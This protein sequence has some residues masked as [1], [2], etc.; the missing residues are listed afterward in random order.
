MNKITVS[1][2]AKLNFNLH[3]LPQKLADG[4]YEVRFLNHQ[5]GLADEIIL[6]ESANGTSLICDIKQTP[7]GEKNLA[8][9]AAQI[10]MSQFPDRGGIKI[11]LKK[12]IPVAGGLGGGSADAA[13]VI[14]GLDK[15]WKLNLKKEE[16]LKIAQ[17]LGMDV[18]Y[19]V[20]GGTCLVTGAG[21][22]IEKLPFSI[23][24]IP[25]L[26]VS[27]TLQKP[28][29]SWAYGQ[30]NSGKIGRN[31]HKLE[32]LTAAIKEKNIVAIAKNLYN[33]FE[34]PIFAVY[35]E[36][37]EIK[38][39]MIESGALGSLLAGSGLSVFGLYRD[40]K[41]A[42]KAYHFLQKQYHQVF[43]TRVL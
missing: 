35:P 43:L 9:R 23:P 25:L 30:L 3:V 18:C 34:E 16:K 20:I 38:E 24:Q 29:T 12:K 31:L 32:G 36:V 39:K 4:Y 40:E 1:A 33:D 21:E 17:N 14:N 19:C 28:S 10:V 11:T 13:A 5:V 2:P 6:E 8:Y 42:Q 41:T 26:I 37:K 22:K 27:P 7:L 15:L